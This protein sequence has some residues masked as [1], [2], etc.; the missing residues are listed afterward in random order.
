VDRVADYVHETKQKLNGEKLRRLVSVRNE[1]KDQRS[2]KRTW[3]GKVAK[4]SNREFE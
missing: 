2:G 3:P 1:K 4:N